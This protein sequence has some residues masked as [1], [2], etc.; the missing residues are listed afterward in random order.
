MKIMSNNDDFTL[1]VFDKSIKDVELIKEY[2]KNVLIEL[3]KRYKKS[4]SGFYNVDVYINDKVGMIFEFKKEEGFDFFK[5]LVDLKVVLHEKARIYLE[6]DDLFLMDS[7]ED[8]Y[9]FENKYYIDVSRLS[10][11]KFYRLLE[12]SQLVFGDK[13]EKMRS[14]FGLVVKN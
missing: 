6:F 10:R 14:N 13:L 4:V 8:V 12:F 9:V 2:L 5:D 11:T 3:K 7:F 1:F